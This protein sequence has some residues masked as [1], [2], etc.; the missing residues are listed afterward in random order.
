MRWSVW[1]IVCLVSELPLYWELHGV[2]TFSCLRTRRL[3]NSHEW[4]KRSHRAHRSNYR[5]IVDHLVLMVLHHLV[6]IFSPSFAWCNTTNILWDG[7]IQILFLLFSLSLNRL[8]LWIVLHLSHLVDVWT[9]VLSICWWI[10][11]IQ[12]SIVV[13]EVLVVSTMN[14]AWNLIC[15][16]IGR[17]SWCIDIFCRAG[18]ANSILLLYILNLLVDWVPHDLIVVVYT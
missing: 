16:P 9:M 15:R 3:L 11:R 14:S 4:S 18:L 17:A 7:H 6:S 2:I 12:S 5:L 13:L 10:W 8:P 1:L